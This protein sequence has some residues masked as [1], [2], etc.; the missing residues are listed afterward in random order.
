M[1]AAYFYD[2][3]KFPCVRARM[4]ARVHL[5]LLVPQPSGCCLVHKRVL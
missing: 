2:L 5:L 3:D 4:Q 1:G